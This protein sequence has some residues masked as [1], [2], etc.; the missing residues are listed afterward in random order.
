LHVLCLWRFFCCYK[1]CFLLVFFFF[2]SRRRHTRYW[3]DWS[4]DVCSSD[5]RAACRAG[6]ARVAHR[7][8]RHVTA[9]GLLPLDRGGTRAGPPP[10]VGVRA[11]LGD[12]RVR[13]AQRAGLTGRPREASLPGPTGRHPVPALTGQRIGVRW[14]LP[15]AEQCRDE[16]GHRTPPTLPR[17]GAARP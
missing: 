17:P 6:G 13:T 15:T 1:A 8:A 7:S 11:Y 12:A 16:T 14:P 2:S 9:V 5:L 10:G 4:S 3:R